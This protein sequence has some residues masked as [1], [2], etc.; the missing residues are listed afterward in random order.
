MYG[1][2]LKNLEDISVD[3]IQDMLNDLDEE[4]QSKGPIEV[5][6]ILHRCTTGIITSIVS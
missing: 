1:N 4:Y 3:L 5:D 2:N 6:A